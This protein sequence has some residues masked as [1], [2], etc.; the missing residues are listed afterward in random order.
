MEWNP[1]LVSHWDAE[2][3]S[4]GENLVGVLHDLVIWTAGDVTVACTVDSHSIY[5][6]WHLCLGVHVIA[7]VFNAHLVDDIAE[8]H[9]IE[10]DL[11]AIK[12]DR[13]TVDFHKLPVDAAHTS[14]QFSADLKITVL[15]QG[16]AGP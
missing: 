6:A 1:D 15:I 10:M 12:Q 8:G 7:V 14:S 2:L 9:H 5:A 3:G 16:K 11:V 13:P 4:N